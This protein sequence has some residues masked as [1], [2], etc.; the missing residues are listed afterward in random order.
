MQVFGGRRVSA[1]VRDELELPFRCECGDVGCEKCVPMTA[2]AYD[3][4]PTEEHG[5]ALAPA[6]GLAGRERDRR[7]RGNGDR[8]LRD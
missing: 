1:G 8:D 4:L 5:L 6:H 3:A 7:Q 2:A